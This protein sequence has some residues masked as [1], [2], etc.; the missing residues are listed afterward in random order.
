MEH[1][2]T[3]SRCDVLLLD[4]MNVEVGCGGVDGR[5]GDGLRAT[6][7]ERTRRVH[8]GVTALHAELQR[9]ALE[10]EAGLERAIHERR[11]QDEHSNRFNNKREAQRAGSQELR[12][13]PEAGNRN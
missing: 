6:N 3:S 13:V 7:E 4:E 10:Q 5:E 9:A 8:L 1:G 2:R 11:K 12:F